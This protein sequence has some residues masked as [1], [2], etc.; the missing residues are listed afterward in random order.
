MTT[1]VFLTDAYGYLT[2]ITQ[3][4]LARYKFQTITVCSLYPSTKMYLKW[5]MAKMPLFNILLVNYSFAGL[6]SGSY[7][8][9]RI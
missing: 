3:V 9:L 2:F 7:E 1:D 5:N 4:Y 8:N 6:T